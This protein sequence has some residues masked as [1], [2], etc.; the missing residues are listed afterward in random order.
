MSKTARTASRSGGDFLSSSPG[1]SVT[2]VT[3]CLA[4]Y[5]VFRSYFSKSQ[6][7]QRII[8]I[9]GRFVMQ[10]DIRLISQIPEK[11]VVFC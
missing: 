7:F 5:V 8:E 6:F 2:M 3:E 10:I 11:T 9:I 1:R 4:L